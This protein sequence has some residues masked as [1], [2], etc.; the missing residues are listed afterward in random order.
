MDRISTEQ[1]PSASHADPRQESEPIAVVGLACIFPGA[2]SACQ[3]W[4][5]LVSAVDSVTEIPPDRWKPDDFYSAD[6]DAQGKSISKWGGFVDTMGYFEP[7]FF[8]IS[9]HQAESMDPQQML[10]LEV[11]W[12]A[13]EDAGYARD[14]KD[15]CGRNY[16]RH[17]GK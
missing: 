13:L 14:S 5:N 8:E 9:P 3:F 16:H 15:K 11:S 4:T 17:P 1:L 10:F 2:N 7:Q 12:Q 6:Q